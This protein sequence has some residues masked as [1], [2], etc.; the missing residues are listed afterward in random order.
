M[1]EREAIENW[2][3][4]GNLACASSG[5]ALKRPAANGRPAATGGGPVATARAPLREDASCRPE[6][7]SDAPRGRER[8]APRPPSPVRGPRNRGRGELRDATRENAR[9]QKD[10]KSANNYKNRAKKATARADEL[11]GYGARA[12]ELAEA[13]L[14]TLHACRACWFATV[15]PVTPGDAVFTKTVF[16]DPPLSLSDP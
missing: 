14:A 12:L 3:R 9:L 5:V 15:P 11:D 6:R 8:G 4:R 1:Y 16:L 13:E 7:S 10:A 2:L